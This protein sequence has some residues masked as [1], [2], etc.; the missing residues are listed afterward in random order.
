[1]NKYLVLFM[2]NKPFYKTISSDTTIEDILLEM[3]RDD[4][5]PVDV[6]DWDITL[7]CMLNHLKAQSRKETYYVSITYLPTGVK[8]AIDIPSDLTLNEVI[9]ELIQAGIL[10]NSVPDFE[11]A[12]Y[13]AFG[14]IAAVLD[15]TKTLPE[16]GISVSSDFLIKPVQR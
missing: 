15:K 6:R 5:L 12:L 7:N 13:G 8:T 3:P 9:I 1:M 14:Q 11:I 4:A 10:P 16:L 2:S